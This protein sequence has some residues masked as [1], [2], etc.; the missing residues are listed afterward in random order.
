MPGKPPSL[1]LAKRVITK[2]FL[3]LQMSNERHY[4][5]NTYLGNIVAQSAGAEEIIKVSYAVSDN[6]YRIWAFPF[7]LGAKRVA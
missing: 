2:A 7:G 3:L 1:W 6:G 4:L 5:F